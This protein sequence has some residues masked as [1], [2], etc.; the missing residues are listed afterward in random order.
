MSAMTGTG[1]K[2]TI[3]ESASASSV[4][5]TATRTISQ[6]AEASA[7]ICAVV[8]S[9]SCVFVSVMDWTTTGA[10]PPIFTPPT[11][12]WRV[13]ATSPQSSPV[14][15]TSRFLED[16]RHEHLRRPLVG[17]VGVRE[18]LGQVALFDG[19]AVDEVRV[20]DRE[21]D[22]QEP[23]QPDGGAD[24][25]EDDPRVDRVPDETVGAGGHELGIDLL[26]HR[27]APVAPDGH[28]R[29][30]RE[31]EPGGEQGEP[32]GRAGRIGVHGVVS[33][34]A[35][36]DENDDE[37]EDDEPDAAGRAHGTRPRFIENAAASQYSQNAAHPISKTSSTVLT[38]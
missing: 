27:R 18:L 26:R 29:P 25:G 3:F 12:I 7:A 19:C 1:E 16:E 22:E 2:R 11:E 13:L 37:N 33:E 38:F 9:T 34:C 6:P 35:Q 15:S 17:G 23:A 36:P 20:G 4:L 21:R 8:A 32:D 10:P 30:D 5:G 28:A 24:P 31:Q 14:C